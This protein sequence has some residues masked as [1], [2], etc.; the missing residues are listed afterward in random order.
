M[1]TC[2]SAIVFAQLFFFKIAFI[3]G[4]TMKNYFHW[5]SLFL[6]FVAMTLKSTYTVFTMNNNV[7]WN[8]ENIIKKD[9]WITS[10]HG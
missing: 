4:P 6:Y 8:N 2:L 1:Y 5:T 7:Y 9:K 10:R 3:F